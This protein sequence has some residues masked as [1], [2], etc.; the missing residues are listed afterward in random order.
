V[1]SHKSVVLST[2]FVSGEHSFGQIAGLAIGAE[3][4]AAVGAFAMRKLASVRRPSETKEEI[5]SEIPSVRP[6]ILAL[7]CP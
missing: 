3:A 1:K 7:E 4:L 6:R 5:G 2:V